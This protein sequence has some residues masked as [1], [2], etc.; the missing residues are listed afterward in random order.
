M[1]IIYHS[2]GRTPPVRRMTGDAFLSL[3]SNAVP[4]DLK[5]KV[6]AIYKE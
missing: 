1:S 2:W 5:A 4:V 6:A 3:W